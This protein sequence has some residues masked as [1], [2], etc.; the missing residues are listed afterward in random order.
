LGIET[1]SPFGSKHAD[2]YPWPDGEAPASISL[3]LCLL[4]PTRRALP[5]IG[6]LVW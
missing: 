6:L 4:S 5:M 3:V 2:K 1:T